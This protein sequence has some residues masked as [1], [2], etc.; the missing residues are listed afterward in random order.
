MLRTLVWPLA[1]DRRIVVATVYTL[2]VV[3]LLLTWPSW[4]TPP[5]FGGQ[6]VIT[7]T[8]IRWLMIFV[9]YLW[10]CVAFN[11]EGER[12]R[13][14]AHLRSVAIRKRAC[15]SSGFTTGA[16]SRFV[17][18]T[19]PAAMAGGGDGSGNFHDRMKRPHRLLSHARCGM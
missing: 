14:G 15:C 17:F 10:G 1:M 6:T 11:S 13:T 8:P 7:A 9:P 4:T 18:G 3:A 5:E 19:L 16:I 2:F 12:R